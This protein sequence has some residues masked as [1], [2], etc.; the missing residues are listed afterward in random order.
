MNRIGIGI[1][2]CN[3]EHFFKELIETIPDVDTI[4]VVN[5]GKPY[6]NEVYPSKIN[7][8]IQHKRKLGIGKTKNDALRYLTNDNC[9]HIFVFEDDVALEDPLAI[10]KYI[11]A[12]KASG[13]LHFNYAYHGKWNKDSANF[14]KPKK[15]I[16]YKNNVNIALHDMLTGALS[17]FRKNVLEDVGLMDPFYKNVLE[18]VDHTYQIIK[19]GYHP[20]FRWFADIEESC[21]LVRE[22]DRDLTQSVNSA[23]FLSVRVRAKLFNK[24]FKMKHGFKPSDIPIASEDECM[25]VLEEIELKYSLN[26]I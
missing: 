4:V 5:D 12:S 10:E 26:K 3:R 20:P 2:T 6:N 13:V 15:I 1:I 16:N 23:G 25:K 19:Q 22:L 24:Y 7:E 17:Y 18:H 14:P 9:E 11:E 21:F 8:V